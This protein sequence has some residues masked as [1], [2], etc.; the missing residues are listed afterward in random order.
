MI[1][2]VSNI[3]QSLIKIISQPYSINGSEAEPKELENTQAIFSTSNQGFGGYSNAVAY[4]F[5]NHIN[6]DIDY[7]FASYKNNVYPNL[8]YLSYK[9]IT[10][11][12]LTSI[13]AHNKAES[14]SLMKQI[15][16][17]TKNMNY[18]KIRLCQLVF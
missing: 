8:I 9:T 17:Y 7:N 16:L 4:K 18:K 6:P 12:I 15:I 2:K 14:N 11:I 1:Y 13:T 10:S 3:N 5:F